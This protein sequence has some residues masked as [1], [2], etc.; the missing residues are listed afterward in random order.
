MDGDQGR[1]NRVLF[2]CGA[3]GVDELLDGGFRSGSLSHIYGEAG[4]GKSTFVL[5][6]AFRALENGYKPV[7]IDAE[8]FNP[9]RFSQISR[10][11]ELVESLIYKE[12]ESFEE[13]S[14][15]IGDIE[16]I[17][18]LADIIIVDSLTRHYRFES[19]EASSYDRLVD[20]LAQLKSMVKRYGLAVIFTNQVYNDPDSGDL[21]PVGGRLI[22]KWSNL[23]MRLESD[24]DQY[25]AVVEKDDGDTPRHGFY[26]ITDRGIE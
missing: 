8:G 18:E 13:Q 17:A 22:A 2:P 25:R 1:E 5:Q 15:T 16:N 21:Y 6:T 11:D 12:V 19:D 26:A 4:T 7:F 3:D 20:Q 24:G 23:I 10:R 9:D 14:R